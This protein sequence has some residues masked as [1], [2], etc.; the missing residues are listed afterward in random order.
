M[1]QATNATTARVVVTL[2]TTSGSAALTTKSWLA[3]SFPSCGAPPSIGNSNALFGQSARSRGACANAQ[4]GR[5]AQRRLAPILTSSHRD[6][7]FYLGDQQ[8]H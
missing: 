7:Q 1:T 8:C 3:R 6:L 2:P 5:A 4:Q